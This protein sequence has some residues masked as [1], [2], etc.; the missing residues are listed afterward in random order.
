VQF[1]G[2]IE[3]ASQLRAG[4]QSVTFGLYKDRTA[5]APLWQETQNVMVE[6]NG[7]FGVLL[8]AGTPGG[9]PVELFTGGDPR[10][11]GVQMN[12]TGGVEEARVLL[13]SVPYALK[14]ADAETLGGRPLSDFWLAAPVNPAAD[15]KCTAPCLNSFQIGDG[16]ILDADIHP[17]AGIAPNKI[18]GTAA[19]LGANTFNGRQTING[20][21]AL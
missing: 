15:P 18:A 14:A 5:G 2:L 3:N 13:V 10:W 6:S 19:T 17:S 16:T 11:V 1:N 20:N 8:G 7:F 4:I 21:L 9:I 12:G